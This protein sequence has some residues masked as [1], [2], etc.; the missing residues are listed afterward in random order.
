MRGRNQLIHQ[1]HHV[2]TYRNPSCAHE[3]RE[4]GAVL[5][6]PIQSN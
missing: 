5:L 1:G 4:R 3:G 2:L 6:A